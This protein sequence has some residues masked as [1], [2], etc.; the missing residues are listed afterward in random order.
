M[1]QNEIDCENP[2]ETMD[3]QGWNNIRHI[4]FHNRDKEVLELTRMLSTD[5]TVI[6]STYGSINSGKT[7]LINNLIKTPTQKSESVLHKPGGRFIS[8]YDEFIK[9]LFGVEPA[10]RYERIKNFEQEELLQYGKINKEKIFLVGR[11]TFFTDP[12]Q[13]TIKPQSRLNLLAIRGVMKSA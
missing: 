5:P 9:V 1:G 7:E 11:N 10:T 12:T 8:N 6:T 13:R 4:E 3:Q 2:N